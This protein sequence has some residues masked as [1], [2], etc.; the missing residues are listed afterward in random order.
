MYL[1]AFALAVTAILSYL[2]F[3]MA[4]LTDHAGKRYGYLFSAFLV[5]AFALFLY[6]SI[7]VYGNAVHMSMYFVFAF[8]GLLLVARFIF[9]TEIQEW[10]GFGVVLIVIGIFLFAVQ[11]FD[12]QEDKENAQQRAQERGKETLLEETPI[13]IHLF[14]VDK[15]L[16]LS[17]RA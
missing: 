16:R 5:A 6:G 9:G 17:V 13:N 1:Y 14:Q 10:Q 15:N 12:S 8:L 11:P 7:V 2:A 4:Y 3:R